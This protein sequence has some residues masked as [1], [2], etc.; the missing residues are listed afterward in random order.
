MTVAE[1][2]KALE[3]ERELGL[4]LDDYAGQWVGVRDHGVVANA[5]TLEELVE[6]IES[7]K[8]GGVEVIQVPDDPAT[9]CFF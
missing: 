5:P 6:Q 2:N 3:A 8:I 7:K 9:V 1:F 4:A